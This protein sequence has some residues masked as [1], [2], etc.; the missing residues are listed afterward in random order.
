MWEETGREEQG[1]KQPMLLLSHECRWVDSLPGVEAFPEVNFLFETG[2]CYVGQA[3]SE[4]EISLP[5]A[6]LP[7]RQMVG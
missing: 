7:S 4:F 2:S 6:T 3:R 5:H 1:D